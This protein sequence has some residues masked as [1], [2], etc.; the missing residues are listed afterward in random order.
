MKLHTPMLRTRIATASLAVAAIAFLGVGCGSSPATPPTSRELSSDETRVMAPP[1]VAPPTNA[2]PATPPNGKPATDAPASPR[3]IRITAKNWAFDPN[4]IHMK[5]G[6]H[7][8]FEVT[9]AEGTHGFAI[10]DFNI[11]ERLALGKTSRIDFTPN[12]TGRF[13]IVCSVPCGPGHRDMRATLVV[14]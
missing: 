1:P 6:E 9:D 11:N 13:V 14:E 2:E 4:E 10:P 8:V 3:V 12:K 5:N 7:V